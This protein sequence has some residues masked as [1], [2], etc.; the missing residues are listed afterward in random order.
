MSSGPR[1]SRTYRALLFLLPRDFRDRFGQDME[2]VFVRRLEESEG[3]L[4]QAWVWARGILDVGGTALRERLP[5]IGGSMTRL[6]VSAL[7]LGL[8]SRPPILHSFSTQ[9]A[10]VRCPGH[11]DVGARRRGVGGDVLDCARSLAQAA[12]LPRPGPPR[13]GVAGA[14]LQQRQGARRHRSGPAS[15]TTRVPA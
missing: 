10:T 14:E 15:S 12:A 4:G 5:A 8:E 7:S 11:R 6:G 3:P 13:G 1:L 9:D 2:E